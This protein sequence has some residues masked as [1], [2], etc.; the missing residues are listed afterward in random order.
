MKRL[1][2]LAALALAACSQTTIQAS[3]YDQSCTAATDCRAVPAG[4]VCACA[5]DYDAINA[6]DEQRYN[7]DYA[8]RRD[9]CSGADLCGACPELPAP[10]CAKGKCVVR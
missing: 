8:E 9:A 5:C 2:A 10:L 6:K 1:A 4:D 3:D 7:A